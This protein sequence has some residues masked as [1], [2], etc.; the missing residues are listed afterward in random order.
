LEVTP[1]EIEAGKRERVETY[2]K[3][4]FLARL[5]D[6][7]R[8]FMDRP[9]QLLF[10]GNSHEPDGFNIMTPVLSGR[11]DINMI[12]FGTTNPCGELSQ[13][14]AGWVSEKEKCDSRLSTLQSDAFI[15]SLDTI[16]YA[17]SG[18]F[19]AK[20]LSLFGLLKDLKT[21]NP[22]LR[23]I[24]IG[25]YLTTN[26]PCARLI[27]ES[28]FSSECR[29]ADYVSHF[30]N[31]P[32]TEALYSEI[33]GLTDIFIDRIEL[34]CSA[35]ELRTCLTQTPTGVPMFHDRHHHLLEFS[36]FTGA[37]LMRQQP[38]L[39]NGLMSADQSPGGHGSN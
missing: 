38:G 1:E 25:G 26:T 29:S 28:G 9:H 35:R 34:L 30:P 37:E 2:R 17:A 4:C 8:C 10:F 31:H 5:D 23:I 32:E 3:S 22:K 24:T 6:R 21:K 15:E 39:L 16:V 11:D 18:P 27:N 19:K 36:R 12:V 14:D 13:T 7:S 33:M 20:K